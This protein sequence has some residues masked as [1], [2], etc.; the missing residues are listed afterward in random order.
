MAAAT[1]II[2]ILDDEPDRLAAMRPLL[3]ERF[4]QYGIETFDNAPDMVRWLHEHLREAVLIS[5]DHDL[6][7]DRRRNGRKFDPGIGRD[8]VDFLATHR[9]QCPVILHTTNRD[10]LPGMREALEET[11]WRVTS[12]M[13]YGDLDWVREAWIDAVH[14]CL[15]DEPSR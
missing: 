2:A 12:V 6:G 5:L 1:S 8:V 14:A 9:P 13:P 11:G 7:P 10:A 3:T 15:G 4:S